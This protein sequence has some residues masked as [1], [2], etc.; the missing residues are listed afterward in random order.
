MLLLGVLLVELCARRELQHLGELLQ[1]RRLASVLILTEKV[2]LI[3]IFGVS[4]LVQQVVQSSIVFIVEQIDGLL[5]AH[6]LAAKVL[7]V[8]L[9][10]EQIVSLLEARRQRSFFAHIFNCVNL[11]K[12]Q[13]RH[14]AACG[15]TQ[16]S[17]G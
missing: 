17:V 16:F 6:H 14:Q 8:E 5:Y 3:L 10:V 13:F 11:Q 1:M 9:A 15:A 4:E 12:G 2:L 7:A